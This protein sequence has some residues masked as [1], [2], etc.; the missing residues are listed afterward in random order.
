[1]T[2]KQ[3]Q[4]RFIELRNAIVEEQNNEMI[5]EGYAVVFDSPTTLYEYEGIEY[6]EI[7]DR[8]AF[9]KC[10]MNDCCLRY[11]HANGF[12]ILARVRGG[13]LTLTI[14][15]NGLKFR[16]KLF[17]TTASRDVYQVIKEGG[18]DKCSFAFAVKESEY[19]RET[20]TRTIKEI[21]RLFDVSVV[22][23]PAYDDTEVSARGFFEAE[24]QRIY[25]SEDETC[26]KR[27]IALL[28]TYL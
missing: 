25:S 2:K 13:S 24:A 9:N 27:K 10:N 1:M 6:K 8:N 28:K 23:T 19:N 22:D 16:A 15:A 7:I 18:L 11:N 17:N 20:H 14:D 5:L 3:K 12:L 26:E 4:I 21:D